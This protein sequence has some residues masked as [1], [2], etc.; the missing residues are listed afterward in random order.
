VESVSY[1]ESA[2]EQ[3]SNSSR[4]TI[5]HTAAVTY[6]IWRLHIGYSIRR[7]ITK[8]GRIGSE[9]PRVKA[10][11]GTFPDARLASPE[12][13]KEHNQKGIAAGTFLEGLMQV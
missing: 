12:D 3:V 13:R 1:L 7:T 9:V 2:R 8:V 6:R 11:R 5:T 10:E 4:S